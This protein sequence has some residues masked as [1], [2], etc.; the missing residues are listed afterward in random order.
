MQNSAINFKRQVTVKLADVKLQYALARL[1][2][3]FV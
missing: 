1:Q 2:T 3:R